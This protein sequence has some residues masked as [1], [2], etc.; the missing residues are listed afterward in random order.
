MRRRFLAL[1]A[2]ALVFLAA[3]SGPSHR[4]SGPTT[5]VGGRAAGSPNP[6]VVPPVITPAYVNAVFAVLN[7]INGN[8]VR[9]MLAA[10]AVTTTVRMDLRAIF[11]DPLYGQEVRIADQ[12]L[13][14]NIQGFRTP[15]GDI[16]TTVKRLISASTNCVFVATVSSFASVVQSPGPLAGAEYWVLRPKPLG[17]DPLNI[18][19]TPWVLSFN[20]TYPTPT[21][22]PNQCF[23]S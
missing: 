12:T 19:P 18:N 13:A 17:D 4:S 10:N 22:I 16:H 6:D 1:A 9:S 14:G 23:A 7:H 2:A 20:A 15:P 11:A 3:C 21:S 5:T 8:A